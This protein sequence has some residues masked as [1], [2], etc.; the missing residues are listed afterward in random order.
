[1]SNIIVIKDENIFVKTFIFQQQEIDN[2]L[3]YITMNRTSK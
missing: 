3:S 1:M 2:T